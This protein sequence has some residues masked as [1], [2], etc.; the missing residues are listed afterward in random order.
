VTVPDPLTQGGGDVVAAGDAVHAGEVRE[1]MQDQADDL[2]VDDP[3][4]PYG[5]SYTGPQYLYQY[6][7]GVAERQAGLHYGFDLPAVR[8][9][10][11]VV[12]DFVAA[13]NDAFARSEIPT[14]SPFTDDRAGDSVV[15]AKNVPM[16]IDSS[17]V[18]I[19]FNTAAPI[20]ADPTTTETLADLLWLV[21]HELTHPLFGQLR[22]VTGD[23][24]CAYP[25]M[26]GR[27]V[28]RRVLLDALDEFRCER[29][30]A[31]IVE[32]LLEIDD[33]GTRRGVTSDDIGDRYAAPWGMCV[34]DTVTVLTGLGQRPPMDADTWMAH[35][36]RLITAIN[37][38][39]GLSARAAAHGRL[40]LAR[41]AGDAGCAAVVDAMDA[42]WDSVDDW[43]YG[44]TQEEFAEIERSYLTKVETTI[45]GL[46]QH[47]QIDL[48]LDDPRMISLA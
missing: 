40:T 46:W 20:V 24:A 33:A 13:V 10:V 25:P 22:A 45:T 30:G 29:V 31:A 34:R 6:V 23:L 21:S 32:S 35:T 4:Q 9:T 38:L 15:V 18:E 48:D 47:F 26:S 28:I 42:I 12:D 37:H 17:R 43:F 3:T 44:T 36:G 16:T 41:F 5:L 19:L 7:L 1:A 11:R 14:Q 27:R 8:L 39:V 2:D